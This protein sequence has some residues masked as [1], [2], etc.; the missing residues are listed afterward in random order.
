[1]DRKLAHLVVTPTISGE[2]GDIE[3]IEVKDI[4]TAATFDGKTGT[5]TTTGNP[6]SEILLKKNGDG[7]WETLLIP[8]DATAVTLTI[9]MANGKYYTIT[10][11]LEG[12]VVE[13]KQYNVAVNVGGHTGGTATCKEQA[14]CE[15]CGEGYGEKL[16]H[17]F[18]DL[19]CTVCG[20][21]QIEIIGQQLNIGGDLAMKYYVEVLD[22]DS[23]RFDDA[24]LTASHPPIL[25]RSLPLRSKKATTWCRPS[26]SA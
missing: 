1:M 2:L 6:D 4:Y 7:T 3:S 9:H 5:V 12:G 21:A 22:R 16:D 11:T 15:Y 19:K 14:K 17:T 23:I 25:I 13:G 18:E 20:K 26:P 10:V 24:Q 8:I